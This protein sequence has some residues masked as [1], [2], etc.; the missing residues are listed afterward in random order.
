MF[1]GVRPGDDSP[2]DES[3]RVRPGKGGMSTVLDDP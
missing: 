1:L 3:G 2:I